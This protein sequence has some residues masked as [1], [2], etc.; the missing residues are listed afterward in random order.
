MCYN[1]FDCIN[2]YFIVRAEVMYNEK[3]Y[4]TVLDKTHHAYRHQF[5]VTRASDYRDKNI[6]PVKRMAMR[7][8][9][10]F[11]QE[12]PVILEEQRIV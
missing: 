10:V 11:E 1:L 2:D 8:H 5:D 7:L 3:L 9:D 4:H 12:T 6:P